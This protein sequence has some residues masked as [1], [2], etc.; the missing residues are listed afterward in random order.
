MIKRI[1]KMSFMPEKVDDFKA[2]FKNNWQYIK[3]FKGCH[4][5]ELLQDKKNTNV[6]FT[7]SM[8]ESEEHLNAYRDSELFSKVWG[9]TKLLFNDKPQAWSVNQLD[10]DF[11]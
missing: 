11:D 3:G 6:F 1:V 7:Y 10:F 8:W 2:I 9:A 5:V 4:H